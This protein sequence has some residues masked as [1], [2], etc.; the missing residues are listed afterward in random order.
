MWTVGE[1]VFV[2]VV[3]TKSSGRLWWYFSVIAVVQVESSLVM[4]IRVRC[5]I[6]FVIGLC[7]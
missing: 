2:E 4:V 6:M 5:C 3:V 7:A 1:Q